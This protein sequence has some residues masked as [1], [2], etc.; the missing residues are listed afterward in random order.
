MVL[1]LF[2]LV[3]HTN[4]QVS[5]VNTND[6]NNDYVVDPKE[7]NGHEA[8][9]GMELARGMQVR[10]FGVKRVVDPTDVPGHSS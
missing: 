5:V 3:N 4:S 9:L 1:K 2:Q 10:C 8:W 6:H 7:A